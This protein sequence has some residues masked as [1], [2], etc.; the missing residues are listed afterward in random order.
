MRRL[1]GHL[2]IEAAAEVTSDD[3]LSRLEGVENE[4]GGWK[5]RCP[6]HEDR[7]PSLSISEGTDGILVYC[8]AGC[9]TRDIVTALQLEMKDLFYDARATGPAQPEAT[10]DYHDEEG[11]FLYRVWRFPNKRFRQSQ[12]VN[13]EW[14][15]NMD[16][17]RKVP[18]RLHKIMWARRHYRTVYIVEGEK[19]ADALERAGKVATTFLGGAKKMIPGYVKYFV[20]LRVIVVR[21]K[22]GPGAAHAELIRDALEGVA[23]SVEVREALVGK[24]AYDHLA[25]GYR[26]EELVKV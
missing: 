21:D 5:A 9:D 23:T 2:G 12:I 7:S 8:H 22:D 25:A 14:V 1:L 10:Y 26:P 4:P 24:D 11:R 6:A 19:D 15:W 16:G 3:F 13:G 20:H 17:V 18:Y